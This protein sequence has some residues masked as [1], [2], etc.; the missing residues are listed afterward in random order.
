MY[1][2][3]CHSYSDLDEKV[4]Y[5]VQVNKLLWNVVTLFGCTN[6]KSL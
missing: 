1:D 5:F 6:E 4:E 2:A 3:K